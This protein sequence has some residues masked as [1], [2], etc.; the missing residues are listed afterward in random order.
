[1]VSRDVTWNNTKMVDR[2]PGKT[3]CPECANQVRPV[4][5]VSNGNTYWFFPHHIQ[6]GQVCIMSHQLQGVRRA[7]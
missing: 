2:S 1:M 3:K 6:N 5:R 7:E 4:I